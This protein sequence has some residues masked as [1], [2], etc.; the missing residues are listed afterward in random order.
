MAFDS[1]SLPGTPD[2]VMSKVL[3]RA[4]IAKVRT[5]G[6]HFSSSSH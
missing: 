2:A 4:E 3:R 5:V 6:L 1:S